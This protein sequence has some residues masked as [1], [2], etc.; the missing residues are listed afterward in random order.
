MAE[1]ITVT[2]T[3][4]PFRFAWR[5]LPL[6]AQTAIA[7][8]LGYFAWFD[9]AGLLLL[10]P[11]PY[12]IL[13]ARTRRDAF[14]IALAHYLGTGVGIV[15]SAQLF[16]PLQ[17]PI[18]SFCIWLLNAGI[19][20]LPWALCHSNQHSG[21]TVALRGS[22]ALVILTLPP[23]GLFHWGSPLLAGG[24]LFPTLGYAA[25]V[26]TVVTIILIPALCLSQKNTWAILLACA[27]LLTRLIS[28][29]VSV[30]PPP[31]NWKGVDTH[32]GQ[33]NGPVLGNNSLLRMKN[34]IDESNQAL[35]AGAK[36]ILFPEALL[37]QQSIVHAAA[38]RKISAR[39]Q[40]QGAVILVG[41]ENWNGFG[42]YHNA[43]NAY[44]AATG[45]S[46]K[47]RVP[48]PLGDWKPGFKGGA[49]SDVFGSDKVTIGNRDAAVSVCYEDLIL[50]PHWFLLSGKAQV[51]LAPSN[52]WGVA[53][54]AA[55]RVQNLSR[56]ALARMAG[57]P[58]VS[59][60]N[61]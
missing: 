6:Y 25:V 49:E 27:L 5:L 50:W 45:V 61:H 52:Q 58:V 16:W 12:L 43:L 60:S 37:G 20:A 23:F 10:L 13:S 28:Q 39:A 38:F 31:A 36:L 7:A 26:L 3:R 8:T 2:D 59:A 11:A 34:V 57:V 51:L 9:F 18:I 19:I 46:F 53:G 41:A 32:H 4:P 15:P 29:T 48:M 42:Y 24:L 14:C 40:E 56:K 1:N 17:P 44:G 55:E 35:N 22:L 33:F 21:K 30:E 47:S 54:T